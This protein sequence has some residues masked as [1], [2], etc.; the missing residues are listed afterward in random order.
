MQATLKHT[1]TRAVT[2]QV[3]RWSSSLSQ[4]ETKS[5]ESWIARQSLPSSQ[6]ALYDHISGSQLNALGCTLPT[7]NGTIPPPP[8]RRTDFS[9]GS[10]VLPGHLLV[11]CNP[12][13]PERELER[14]ATIRI[15]APPMPFVRRMWAAG[16]FE[17]KRPLHVG[18]NIKAERAVSTIGAKR[19]DSENPMIIVEQIIHTKTVEGSQPRSPP[20]MLSDVCVTETRSHVYVP[21]TNERRVRPIRDLPKPDFSF[22]YTPTDTTLFHFSAL[23]FNAHRIHLD[24]DYSQNVENLPE[25]LVHGPMTALILMEAVENNRPEHLS[26]DTF[27]YRATNQLFVNQAITVHGNWVSGSKIKLWAQNDDGVVGMV[28]EAYLKLGVA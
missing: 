2:S 6:P 17:F 28:G 7:L 25:R 4:S 23:T 16:K 20:S 3:Q 22:S 19:L 26:I 12:H 15:L 13:A 18:D 9:Y 10:V 5:V 14:D 24:K 21:L 1:R 27:E 11:F 8:H